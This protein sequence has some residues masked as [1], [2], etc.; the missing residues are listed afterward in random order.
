MRVQHKATRS[1]IQ[2]EREKRY[3]ERYPIK[4]QLEAFCENAMGKPEKLKD[5]IEGFAKIREAFP[6]SKESE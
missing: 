3:L 1:E 2:A 4:K 6:F 5:L